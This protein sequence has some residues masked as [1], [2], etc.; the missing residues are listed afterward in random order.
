MWEHARGA[1][2]TAIRELLKLATAVVI[3]IER[4][5]AKQAVHF[6]NALMAGVEL[7]FNVCDKFI[8]LTHN[9]TSFN[10]PV[11]CWRALINSQ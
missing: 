5:V 9:Y 7:A 8:I 11:I 2:L 3:M 6:T 10:L 1:V 4:A